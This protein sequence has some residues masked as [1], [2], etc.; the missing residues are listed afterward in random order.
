M[1][2][3][4]KSLAFGK[5]RIFQK[6]LLSLN[7]KKIPRQE[8]EIY[9]GSRKTNK[10]ETLVVNVVVGIVICYEK[11]RRAN[12]NRAQRVRAKG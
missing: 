11:L 7:S 4:Y 8:N 6:H 5:L 12:N 2:A 1:T 3:V 10:N 9:Y